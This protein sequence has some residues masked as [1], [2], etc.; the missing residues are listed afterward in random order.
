MS[1]YYPEGHERWCPLCHL[2]FLNVDKH[3][4]TVHGTVGGTEEQQILC[5]LGAD[6]TPVEGEF[7]RC[8]LFRTTGCTAEIANVRHHIRNKHPQTTKDQIT[9]ALRP[10]RYKIAMR[11]LKNLRASKKEKMVTELDLDYEEGDETVRVPAPTTCRQK[12]CKDTRKEVE[13]LKRIN[14]LQRRELSKLRRICV[15]S[16]SSK[17]VVKITKLAA[18]PASEID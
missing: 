17:K 6:R 3:L 12:Q 8:P 13:T 15:S 18:L 1:A 9:R 2:S 11:L 7:V 14:A 5:S 16:E 10:M 4:K